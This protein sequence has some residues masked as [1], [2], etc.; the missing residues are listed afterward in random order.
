[1]KVLVTGATGY[2]GS[3]LVH[4][5]LLDGHEVAAF[6]RDTSTLFRLLDVVDSVAWYDSDESNISEP[7]K[8]HGGFDAVIHSATCY[9]R[10]GEPPAAVFAANAVFPVRLLDAAT[11]FNTNTY[12]NTDTVLYPY[13]NLYALSK[14][15]FAE[16]GKMV[17]QRSGIRFV[18]I[19]L[20]HFYGPY[21]DPTKFTT[22]IIR[23]CLNNVPAIDLTPGEQLRDF[24][25]IDDTVD[26]FSKL[27]ETQPLQPGGYL[28]VGLGAGVAV[29]V[30]E[31]V[32]TVHN[33]CNSTSQL[34]FGA[35]AYREHEIMQSAADVS[36]LLKLG[37]KQTVTLERGLEKT[38]EA[39]KNLS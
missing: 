28:D 29:T 20:E 26:A 13:I 2:L 16:W 23:Q 21:D 22:H 18:N 7:F 1:M 39:E 33:L 25:Y 17:S 15:Q 5:L 27:F 37:W 11:Y 4:R 10:N 6:K 12:F 30:R 31:F 35:L 3:H 14:K 9:G 32:E 36:F 19:R 8:R 34:N 38:I 24:L